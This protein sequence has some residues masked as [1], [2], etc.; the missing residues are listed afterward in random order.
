MIWRCAGYFFQGFITDIQN[1]CHMDQPHIFLGV[2]KLINLKSEIIKIVQ[3]HS[4]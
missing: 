4:P 1:S 2:Q 3:S